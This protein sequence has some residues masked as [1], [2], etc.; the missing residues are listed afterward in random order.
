MSFSQV[1][2]LFRFILCINIKEVV[3]FVDMSQSCAIQKCE[4][5]SRATC[6]CCKQ[7]LCLQHLYEHNALLVAQLNPLTDEINVLADRIN[8][9][10]LHEKTYHCRQKLEQWRL[11]CHRAIDRLFEQKCEELDRLFTM[12]TND[13]REKISEIQTKLGKFIREQEATRQD[14]DT[15]TSTIRHLGRNINKIEQECFSV[16]T[17][18][19]LID[20]TIVQFMTSSAQEFNSST[21]SSVYKKVMHAKESS[22]PLAS[23]DRFLLMHQ[24]PN[25][26]LL[27]I[28]LTE[29][30]HVLWSYGPISDMC[31]S[32]TLDR[33]IVINNDTIF[34]VDD[35]TMSINSVQTI[36]KQNWFS[37]AC[38]NESLFLSTNWWGSPILEARLSSPIVVVK[39]W[40]SPST[41]STDELIDDMVYNDGTLALVIE[42]KVQ[43]STRIELR[44]CKTLNRLWSLLLDVKYNFIDTFHCCS[45]SCNEWLVTDFQADRLLHITKDGKLKQTITC[46]TP[47]FINLFA[48]N[49]L[50]VATETCVNFYKT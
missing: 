7:N 17:Y 32:T 28:E 20:D 37:C 50:V 44:S 34:L 3:R 27:N 41:C 5:T 47:Y 16:V 14:I 45:I 15:L 48:S 18:P 26:C 24:E 49:T 31:W 33:F 40:K 2:K 22:Y 11:D 38:F 10:N 42:N 36:Q 9:F 39:E 25:L 21:L 35:K 43:K 19:L 6:D 30:K 8:T 29:V 23:N 46:D 4:R 13:Q 1:T 12:K